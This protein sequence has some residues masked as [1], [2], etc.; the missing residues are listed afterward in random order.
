M[1]YLM[2]SIQFSEGFG[3]TL[4]FNA[5]SSN[6]NIEY[7]HNATYALHASIYKYLFR[8]KLYIAL[9]CINIAAKDNVVCSWNASETFSDYRRHL[10]HPAVTFSAVFLFNNYNGNRSSIRTDTIQDLKNEY[11]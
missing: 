3:M 10:S 1:L 11:K 7:W 9:N 8:K 4:Q 2:N 6:E 5:Q